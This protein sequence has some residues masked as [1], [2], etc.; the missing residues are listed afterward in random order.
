MQI[1]DDLKNYPGVPELQVE[2]AK[3]V[4]KCRRCD[5]PS[6]KMKQQPVTQKTEKAPEPVIKEVPVFET[7]HSEP[8]IK[9]EQPVAEEKNLRLNKI[10]LR[11]LLRAGSSSSRLSYICR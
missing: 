8:V 6:Q 4:Q 10:R 5:R 7:K 9:A 3:Q 2:L 11:N 1:I